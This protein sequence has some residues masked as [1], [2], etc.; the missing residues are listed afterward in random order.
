MY[1]LTIVYAD[2]GILVL[3]G[4]IVKWR[5]WGASEF[6]VGNLNDV[7]ATR[8]GGGCFG[9]VCIHVGDWEPGEDDER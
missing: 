1:L 7:R 6:I 3:N 4:V 8:V 9:L 2:N 5:L